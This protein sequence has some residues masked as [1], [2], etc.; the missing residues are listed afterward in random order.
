VTAGDPPPGLAF[1]EPICEW[2]VSGTP[3]HAGTS[4]DLTV[5][6]TSGSSTT[7]LVRALIS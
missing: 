3:T 6:D 4:Y 1:G 2:T 5:T 7:E